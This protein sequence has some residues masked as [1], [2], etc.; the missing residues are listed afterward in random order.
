ML[1]DYHMCQKKTLSSMDNTALRTK[2]PYLLANLMDETDDL[3]LW[4]ISCAKNY[5]EELKKKRKQLYTNRSSRKE[6]VCTGE[7]PDQRPKTLVWINIILTTMKNSPFK[8]T[9]STCQSSNY[10]AIF[11]NSI[12]F[13]ILSF[14]V[15][16]SPL[17]KTKSQ[18]HKL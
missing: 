6:R 5:M 17:I 18:N 13:F 4:Q 7:F 15:N 16:T 2:K 1:C 9:R 8:P 14:S 12:M 11:T 3:F 10:T